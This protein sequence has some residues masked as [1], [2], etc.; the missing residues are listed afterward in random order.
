MIFDLFPRTSLKTFAI[1]FPGPDPG[2][3]LVHPPECPMVE[4]GE[5]PAAAKGDIIAEDVASRGV[6][7][8]S[9]ALVESSDGKVTWELKTYS[10]I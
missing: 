1:L 4:M 2:H 7:V 9:V 3:P 5:D 6:A 10:M 8:G